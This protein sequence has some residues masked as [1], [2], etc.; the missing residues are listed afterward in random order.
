MINAGDVVRL[1][2]GGERMTVSDVKRV[3]MAATPTARCVWF[4]GTEMKESN[5]EVAALVLAP[6]EDEKPGA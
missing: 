6:D 2:S 4:V 3:G 5:I 1:K